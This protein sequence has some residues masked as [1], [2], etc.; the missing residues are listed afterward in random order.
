VAR[1]GLSCARRRASRT[2]RRR[3]GHR[4]DNRPSDYWIPARCARS[5]GMTENVNAPPIGLE[6]GRVQKDEMSI[7][8]DCGGRSRI[9]A[10]GE[11]TATPPAA[12]QRQQYEDDQQYEPDR[13]NRRHHRAT[14][15]F[16]SG[17]S[18]TCARSTPPR[19]CLATRNRV[20]RRQFIARS[21][22]RRSVSKT[23]H[24]TRD[25][26]LRNRNAGQARTQAAPPDTGACPVGLPRAQKTNPAEWP[27]RG[28]DPLQSPVGGTRA[29]VQ[30]PQFTRLA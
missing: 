6:S 5:A 28:L 24:R 25:N 21:S 7:A 29:K 27:R 4:F 20:G 10:S 19:R 26:W 2:H 3:V 15:L 17:C 16:L 1:S 12:S 11:S 23:R 14:S 22:T 13:D 30:H 9:C 18:L 8:F